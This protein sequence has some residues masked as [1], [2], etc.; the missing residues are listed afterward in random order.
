[1]HCNRSI[2]NSEAAPLVIL[3]KENPGIQEFLQW[4]SF[5]VVSNLEAS[6]YTE[7]V[8]KCMYKIQPILFNEINYSSLP[9]ST[10]ISKPHTQKPVKNA[11]RK[12]HFQE[13]PWNI[14]SLNSFTTG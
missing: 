1:M 4:N 2:G 12:G 8:S 11:D 5:H 10:S 3:S 9:P 7:F 6:E 14:G 13:V